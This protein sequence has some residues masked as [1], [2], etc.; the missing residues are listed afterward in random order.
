L[1]NPQPRAFGATLGDLIDTFYVA[2]FLNIGTTDFDVGLQGGGLL[3]DNQ[4]SEEVGDV[5]SSR[6]AALGGL[7]R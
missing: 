2:A 1:A 3:G 5:G 6:A 4:L 7:L